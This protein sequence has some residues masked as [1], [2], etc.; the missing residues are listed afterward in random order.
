MEGPAFALARVCRGGSE[1]TALVRHGRVLDLTDVPLG[2]APAGATVRDLLEHWDTVLPELQALQPD[3]G[4]TALERSELRAPIAPRQILQ[5][6]ANYRTHVLDLAVQH[7]ELSE[8]RTPAQVRAAAAASLDLRARE[9]I[10]YFFL[11]LNT[12]IA[13]PFDD[14]T[15]PAYSDKHDWELELVAVIGRRAW[16]VGRDEALD[17]V[18]GYTIGNDLTTRDLVFRRDMPEIGTDWFRAKNAPGFLPL[19]PFVVPATE[20]P[21]PQALTLT[22]RLNGEVMQDEAASDM[23]FDVAALVSHA[24]Q[25]VPLLP[26][27]LVWTGSPAG[28]GMARG[29]LLRDGDVMESTI[30]GLGEQ[31][32]RCVAEV[33]A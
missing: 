12:A 20:V 1:F 11:G 17:H 19:G 26:G 13:G 7:T 33:P 22:L 28:N 24:S 4:W 5:A 14:V 32:T 10:P 2:D 3:A 21:D 31:R 6:G 8:G 25:T 18:A 16:R 23:I 27:D 29:R 15:L 9:G 30:T